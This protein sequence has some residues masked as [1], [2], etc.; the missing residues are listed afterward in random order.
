MRAFR[1][2]ST[3]PTRQ[4]RALLAS[5]LVS[6]LLVASDVFAQ[7][8]RRGHPKAMGTT[9]AIMFVLIGAVPVGAQ[10]IVYVDSTA[11]GS[12]NGSSW[13]DAFVFLQ[14]ALAVVGPG[15]EV[16][17]ARGIYRPDQGNDVVV[18]DR[19][20]SFVL[21]PGVRLFGGFAGTESNA[22]VRDWNQNPFV[23]SGDLRGDDTTELSEGAPNRIENSDRVLRVTA[24]AASARP[25]LDGVVVRGGHAV[26]NRF[27]GG[28]RLVQGSGI[29]IRN[30]TFRYNY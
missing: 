13:T 3:L 14:D 1:L 22:T 27:G 25:L 16:W 8:K 26:I 30:S 10:S 23:L 15:D 5:L 12:N 17:I 29:T 4:I 7:R 24:G 2:N 9:V 28:L 21:Q 18:G 6:L 19:D 20:T 11:A